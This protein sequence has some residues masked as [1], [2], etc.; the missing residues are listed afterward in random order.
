[1]PSYY[2]HGLPADLDA[3]LTATRLL[4]DLDFDEAK[5]GRGPVEIRRLLIQ[6]RIIPEVVAFVRVAC[7]LVMRN[8]LAIGAV[9]PVVQEY[10]QNLARLLCPDAQTDSGWADSFQREV[11]QT[12]AASSEWRSCRHQIADLA[13][14]LARRSIVRP[15]PVVAEPLIAFDIKTA[16]LDTAQGR[17]TAVN[18]FLEWCN[19]TAPSKLTQQHVWKAMGHGDPRQLQYWLSAKPG[20][21]ATRA[22]D[23]KVHRV[24][25]MSAADFVSLLQREG[26]LV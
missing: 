25:R 20:S 10:T 9:E 17:R 18:S 4:A 3:E 11:R 14:G 8:W 13:A 24:L 16:D 19:R 12:I 22:T 6:R 7:E 1:M 23:E 26:H 5:R 15:T 21:K 2:S